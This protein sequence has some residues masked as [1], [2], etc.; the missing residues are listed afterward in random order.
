[1]LLIFWYLGFMILGDICAYFIGLLVEYQWGSQAS[2]MVFLALYF[3]FLWV[4][5]ILSVWVTKPKKVAV[6]VA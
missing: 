2:L 4:S 3:I 5:W 1:M 6:A